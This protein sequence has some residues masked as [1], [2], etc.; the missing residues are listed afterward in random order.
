MERGVDGRDGATSSCMET[1]T[2]GGDGRDGTFST[3]SGCTSSRLSDTGWQMTYK[4][5]VMG[6]F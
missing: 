2:D 3:A 5:V 4:L 6:L 1:G